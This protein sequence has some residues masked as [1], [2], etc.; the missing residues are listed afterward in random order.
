MLN[1]RTVS[2]L[3]KVYP[4]RNEEEPG[5]IISSANMLRNGKYSYQVLFRSVNYSMGGI[6]FRVDADEKIKDRISVRYVN[7]VPCETSPSPDDAKYYE[8]PEPGV[9]PDIL[10]PIPG[11]LWAYSRLW[12]SLW[13]TVDGSDN[14]IEPGKYD[15]DIV[16]LD[17]SENKSH[18]T[19]EVLDCRVPDI[20]FPVTNWFHSDGLCHYYHVEYLSDEYWRIAENFVRTAV[21]NGISTI[22]T[23]VFTP[24]LDTAQGRERLT[25]QLVGV[26]KNGGKYFFDFSNLGKWID[27]CN[28][29][30]VDF[31]EISHV[32]TQWGCKYAPKVMATVDGEYKRIFGWDTDGHGKEYTKFLSKFLPQLR[33]YLEAKGVFDRCFFHVSDEPSLSMAEDYGRC[34]EFMRKY[35]PENQIIDALSEYEF[36]RNGLIKTPVVS[37]GSIH[38]FIDN[39]VKN[40]WGY[41]C[42]GPISTSNRFVQTSSSKNRILGLQLFKY[43]IKG[44]LQWGYNFY[45]TH[46][47]VG[48]IN[49][50][51]TCTGGGWVPG[52]D[53]FVVYPGD[54][55]KAI[56][57]IRLS[58]FSDA[59]SDFKV[60]TGLLVKYSREELI[61]MLGLEKLTFLDYP[62]DPA[63]HESIRNRINAMLAEI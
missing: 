12:R 26:E 28:R 25:T 18:F 56:E 40:L 59:I 15:I 22:L 44:F 52:G 24:P 33:K 16:L 41:Y 14:E 30:G 57:S 32:Y 21:K 63:L 4:D 27:M 50:Y 23:S 2:S 29:V 20:K 34:A 36:Y 31:F 60:L 11:I 53:P 37:L 19:M 6:G 43:D 5:E 46:M 8:H 39:G 42:C 51:S 10:G 17:G 48:S 47:S 7:Y 54:D 58:V 61:S 49:P 55:G 38:T 3:I 1:I 45:N 9:M 35:I 62:E 13:I